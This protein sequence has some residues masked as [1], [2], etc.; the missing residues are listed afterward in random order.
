MPREFV[1]KL[2]LDNLT[3]IQTFLQSHQL[4]KVS[5]SL[6]RANKFLGPNEA[7]TWSYLLDKH[8]KQDNEADY[9]DED[10]DLETSAESPPKISADEPTNPTKDTD[11]ADTL[12]P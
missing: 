6:F 11:P 2:T 1:V 12:S 7:K 8:Q 3:K 4:Q 5:N 10:E 9:F